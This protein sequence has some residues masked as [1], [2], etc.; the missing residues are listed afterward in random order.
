MAPMLVDDFLTLSAERM[1]GK[2]A[3]VCAG[4]RIS[5][6]EL[7]AQADR[8]ASMLADRGI[9]RGD[10]VAV[11]LDNSIEAAIAIFGILK[12]GAIFIV[13]SQTI[14]ADKLKFIL[15][16]SAACALVTQ[17]VFLELLRDIDNKVSSLD[18]LV[19]C[20][21]DPMPSEL[22]TPVVIF[23]LED[24]TPPARLS[25]RSQIDVDV[26]ALI[27]TSGST[28]F[29][30]GVTVSHRNV[31][32]AATSITEYL[33]NVDDDIIINVLPFSFDYGLYQLLMTVKVGA[34]LV[35]EKSFAYPFK[36]I[37]RVH[38]ERVTGFPGVPTIFAVLLQ[39]T[40]LDTSLLE[41]VRYVTNTAAALPPHHIDRLRSLF[42]NARLFSMYGL[43]ECKRVSYL[44]P[45][46]LD[47][48][49]TSVGRG[50]PNTEIFVVDEEGRRVPP[51]V[52]GELV[53]RGSNVMLG[54]WNRPEE[55]AEVIRPGR[56]PWER[57]LHT[58]D[59]FRMDQEGFFY[60]VAR[61]DEIIK[62][63]GEKVSPAEVERIIHELDEVLE[64]AV[65]GVPDPILGEA[66]KALVVCSSG[67]TVTERDVITHCSR[68][69]ES[70]MVPK[71]VEFRDSLPKTS[72]GKIARREVASQGGHPS[73]QGASRE[74]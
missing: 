12:A 52:V 19:S 3:I 39:M 55:T 49:P 25:R 58:G 64:V 67:C 28:G 66:L 10:R 65:I 29:P 26:A 4:V 70:F 11:L 61:K 74:S 37:Q 16:D 54:Y 14:K 62:S 40:D 35:L 27:Y 17:P 15:D 45:E 31:I 44:P 1:P 6:G 30:K 21:R 38:E 69:L 72:S 71:E 59:L 48:R 63:R 13:V 8:F 36:I 18:F 56:Y 47:S 42:K 43:T 23:D 20:S 2:T 9:N 32:S 73:V 46:E 34:T 5:Y 7:D 50:M 41:S 60:F 22:E 57:V 33:Q 51:G 68:R 24:A 53:V